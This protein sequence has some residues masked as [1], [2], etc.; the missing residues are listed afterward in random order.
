MKHTWF[1]NKN[2]TSLEIVQYM[3]IS[4]HKVKQSVNITDIKVIDDLINRIEKINPQG[5]MYISFSE[6]AEEITLL[7]HSE[8]AVQRIEIIQG[9]FKTPST[10]FNI[11]N[12]KERT[13]YK[14][15]VA[16]LNQQMK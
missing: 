10:S 12:E 6:E 3:S 1:T 15:I 8:E 9:G 5:D 4:D 14:D 13:L 2:C 16:L 7:F 11:R